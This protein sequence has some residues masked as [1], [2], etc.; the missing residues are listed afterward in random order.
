MEMLRIIGDVY[1]M[2]GGPRHALGR[3]IA[4]AT[5]PALESG[6]ATT[7]TALTW[8]RPIAVYIRRLNS[9]RYGSE[10]NIMLSTNDQIIDLVAWRSSDLGRPLAML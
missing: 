7:R 3:C 1:A 8:K 5:G 4:A 6:L 10:A 2:L 9:D